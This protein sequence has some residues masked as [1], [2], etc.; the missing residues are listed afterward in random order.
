[1]KRLAIYLQKPVIMKQLIVAFVALMFIDIA[2]QAQAQEIFKTGRL[3]YRG[4]DFYMD[5]QLLQTEQIKD[6]I[7]IDLFNY[8]YSEAIT[9]KNVGSALTVSGSV[10]GGV[11]AG[12]VAFG[13]VYAWGNTAKALNSIIA[14][15]QGSS[16]DIVDGANRATAFVYAGLGTMT[17]GTVLLKVGIP[18]YTIGRRRLQWI[19]SDYNLGLTPNG[20][21]VAVRF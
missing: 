12:L 15:G 8:T 19:A 21:G 2:F 17:L 4:G 6:V 14:G 9:Q 3:E 11:G 1:M 10:L 5:G 16:Q 7:G 18:L 20:V 13:Y